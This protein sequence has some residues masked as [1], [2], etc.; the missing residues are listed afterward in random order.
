ML[1]SHPRLFLLAFVRNLNIS[2]AV[3]VL[4][5]SEVD[6]ED[7]VE[8]NKCIWFRKMCAFRAQMSKFNH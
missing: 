6:F 2:E 8:S 4:C 3:D 7:L 5:N 1:K